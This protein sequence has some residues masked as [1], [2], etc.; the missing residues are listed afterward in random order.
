MELSLESRREFHWKNG[1]LC[2]PNRL[3]AVRDC[4]SDFLDPFEIKCGNELPIESTF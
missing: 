2:S 1:A 4:A 3:N